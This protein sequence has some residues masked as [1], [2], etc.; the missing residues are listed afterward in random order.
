MS[1]VVLG[2]V[3]LGGFV[4]LKKAGLSIVKWD[5]SRVKAPSSNEEWEHEFEEYKQHPQFIS[6]HPNMNIETFKYIYKLEHYHRQLGKALGLIFLLPFTYFVVRRYIK[7]R[8]IIISLIT[9]AL[10]GLQGF[11]G[12]WMVRSGLNNKQE[13]DTDRDNLKGE[14]KVSHY[15]LAFHF[16]MSVLIYCLLLKTGLFLVSKPQIVKSPLLF[17]NSNNKIRKNLLLSFHL[18][19]ATLIWGS[20]MAGTDSGKIVNTFPKMGDIW[21]PGKEHLDITRSKLRNLSENPIFIHFTHRTLATT[22]FILLLSI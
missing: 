14:V 13:T 18:A 10:G 7:K 19:Y 5:L 9:F 4:R 11:I 3:S 2:M 6:N 8:L 17:T 1:G 15:R 21:Y 22:T 12:W 20:F 16:S